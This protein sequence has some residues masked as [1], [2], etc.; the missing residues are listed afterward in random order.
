[1]NKIS[2]IH[3]EVGPSRILSRVIALYYT[4]KYLVMSPIKDTFKRGLQFPS[5]SLNIHPL[6]G[7]YQQV[8]H[9]A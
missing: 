2:A 9:N 5:N 7:N 8:F 4:Y 6:S 1:M 3:F